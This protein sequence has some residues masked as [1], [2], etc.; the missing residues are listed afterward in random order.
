MNHVVRNFEKPSQGIVPAFAELSTASIYEAAGQSGMMDPAIRAIYPAA[1][2]CGTAVTVRCHVGD[3]LMLHKA[4]TVAKPGDVLVATIGNHLGAG[5]WGEILTVAAMARGIKG[6]VIDGAVRDVEA[7]QRRDFPVFARG[8]CIGATM[9]R[10]IGTINHPI[11]CGNMLVEAGDIIVAD[12]DGVVVVPRRE[13]EQVLAST[14]DREAKE[15]ILMQQLQA[16]AT[17]LELLN[18]ESVLN[19]L[20]LTEDE[21]VIAEEL[22][23]RASW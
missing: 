13:A 17:T 15:A 20:G 4:V 18:L 10:N 16:G 9:K 5:A 22:P 23:T 11:I 7:M 3:N 12:P 1:R 6:L 8:V 19:D 2:I 21:E 14:R